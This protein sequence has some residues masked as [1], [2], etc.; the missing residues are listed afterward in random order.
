[1]NHRYPPFTR[2]VLGSSL[3]F[4]LAVAVSAPRA[5]VAQTTLNA[6]VGL[7]GYYKSQRW[8]PVR[9][10]LTHQGTP[11]KVEV[12]GRFSQ[13]LE[14][15]SEY[16]IP[17]RE[18]RSGANEQHN[19]YI[20]A[21]MSYS[22]QPLVLELYRDGRLLN[23]VKPQL[24]LVND[25]DW[26]VLGIGSGD[27]SLKQL[28]MLTL[29]AQSVNPYASSQQGNQQ[30][31]VNVAIQ[32][33]ARVPDQWQGLD[34]ADMVVLGGVSERDLSPEQA[35]AIRDYVTAGGTL[36]VT[37]GANWNRLTTPFFRDLLPVDVTGGAT[38]SSADGLN[39]MAKN[40][41]SGSAYAA[42]VCRPHPGARV[43]AS[44]G[45]RPLVVTGTRGSGRVTFL[46][47]DPSAPPFRT[48]ED[49]AGLWKRLLLAER[50]PGSVVRAVSYADGAEQ[51]GGYNRYG[52]GQLR[53]AEAP[54]AIPQLDIPA[55]YIVATFLLAYIVVLVPVNYFVLKAKDKK[56]YAWLTTPAIVLVFSIGAYMIGYGF[57]GGRTL[58]VKAGLVEAHAGQKAAPSV[59]YSGLFSPRKTAYDIR[60]A[61]AAAKSD[62][63]AT[64]F[65]E[66]TA[67]NPSTTLR[68]VNEDGQYV[69]DFAVDMWAMRVLKSEGITRLGS[70]IT[71]SIQVKGKHVSGTIR[72]G[73][74]YTIENAGVYTS[75][76][77][78]SVPSLAPGQQV[79]VDAEGKAVPSGAV[80]P[81]ELL[82]E[83]KGTRE[84]QRMKRAVL[85]PLIA[86]TPTGGPGWTRPTYPMLAGWIK[87]PVGSLDID[88]RQPRELAAT[89]MLVHLD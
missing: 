61:S 1:M 84:E 47:F 45:D 52:N 11:A 60:L 36:V 79:T 20:R 72:N 65:S 28:T 29:P 37:G 8:F 74:P 77:Y 41:P 86:G 85:Q 4:A 66:P 58:V 38:L 81:N 55:F 26:L 75:G 6:D 46:A 54:Y 18:L 33:P 62:D 88:G 14:G 12:R 17:P 3:V 22:S 10:T 21:P 16:R 44:Q 78:A 64:L 67:Q 40:A 68:S 70:G 31:K 76:V 27:S 35:N 80:V 82:N 42:A 2:W 57:K 39:R 87:E 50:A 23:P 71:A 59:F 32:S 73:S 7:E 89:L 13:G 19:L 30:P 9:V 34:A 83:V 53:L 63:S 56:E 25:G 49:G 5:A 15:A 24:N 69:D 43:L 48:W 51:F